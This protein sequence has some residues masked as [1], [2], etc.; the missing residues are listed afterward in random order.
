MK[1]DIHQSNMLGG[2]SQQAAAQQFPSQCK[3]LTNGYPS[4]V[5]GL[6]R[7]PPTQHVGRLI[8][9]D[10][11]ESHFHY[12]DRDQDERYIVVVGSGSIQVFDLEGNAKTVHSPDGL[13]YLEC[14]SPRTQLKAL[15]LADY[16]FIVNTTVDVEK[17]ED[18]APTVRN[19]E[20]LVFVKQGAYSTTYTITGSAG[21]YSDST[22]TGASAGDANTEAIAAALADAVVAGFT[23]TR[24]G[25]VIWIRADGSD[26][27]SMTVSDGIGNTGLVLV[28]D[29]VQTFDDL[30]TTA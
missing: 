16:T 4:I 6:S 8:F 2:V 5:D 22:T 20:A 7:R 28:K 24:S 12:I 1:L 18:S 25:S 19:P 27:F 9:G 30:P 21:A 29:S 11:P 3:E 15:T 13:D 14:D 26:D 17:D 23:V 10:H